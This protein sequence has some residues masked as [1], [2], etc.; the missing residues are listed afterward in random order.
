MQTHSNMVAY[1]FG[2]WTSNCRKH[3]YIM[4]VSYI[5]I[6]AYTIAY[7]S[8]QP[9]SVSIRRVDYLHSIKSN[10]KDSI[11]HKLVHL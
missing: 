1:V 11:S 5:N 6:N 8:V 10:Y 4:G 9:K 7:T 3:D 2:I